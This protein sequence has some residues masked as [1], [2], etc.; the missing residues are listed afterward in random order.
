MTELSTL[1]TEGNR[2]QRTE[3]VLT[4]EDKPATIRRAEGK[5]SPDVRVT[6]ANDEHA[7]SRELVRDNVDQAVAKLND[8][9]QS[10]QRDLRFFVDRTSGRLVVHVI[11]SSTDEVVRKIPSDVALRLARNL[12]NQQQAAQA[13]YAESVPSGALGLINTRI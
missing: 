10:T 9:V 12:K 3:P 11:E 4:P 13:T 8:Y 5:E 7:R 2:P 1:Q 6:R